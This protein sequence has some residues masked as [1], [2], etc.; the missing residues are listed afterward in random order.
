M[1]KIIYLIM[2]LLL[3]LAVNTSSIAQGKEKKNTPILPKAG[4]FALGVNLIPFL[5]YTGN[6]FNGSTNNSINS[7]GAQ[8]SIDKAF[9]STMPVISIKGKYMKTDHIAYRLNIGVFN[10]KLYDNFYI[11]DD[12]RFF[13]DPLSE[14]KVIDY[15]KKITSSASF[16][17]GIEFRKGHHRIQG[18]I[19]GDLF[20]GFRS[21]NN[22]YNYGNAITEINQRPSRTVM[23]LP[24]P[25]NIPYWTQ[26]YVMDD[27]SKVH[28]FGLRAFVGVEYFIASNLSL[29][30]EIGLTGLGKIE[31]Q[32]YQKQEGFNNTTNEVESRTELLKPSLIDFN[33]ATYDD[34][35]GRLY[36]TFYF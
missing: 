30:G 28:Y 34:L 7:F 22:I 20:Y 2:L 16:S 9:D 33:Y 3:T 17:G 13:Q 6:M 4:D 15:Y 29:G 11:R 19:G 14:V 31:E 5:N 12:A 18:Y 32:S 26:T 24:S 10:D 1:K 36:M 8:P 35:G 21:Q 27:F 23:G 25:I